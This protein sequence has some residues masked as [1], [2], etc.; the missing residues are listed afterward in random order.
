[1]QYN[2]MHKLKQYQVSTTVMD[3]VVVFC[4]VSCLYSFLCCCVSLSLPNYRRIKIYVNDSRVDCCVG[5]Y[6]ADEVDVVESRL[7]D[8]VESHHA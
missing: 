1:M 2:D 4:I 7:S 5:W 3:L 8:S 6:L